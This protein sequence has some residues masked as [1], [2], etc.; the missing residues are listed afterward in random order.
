M[1]KKLLEKK[2]QK[3]WRQQK[4]AKKWSQKKNLQRDIFPKIKK[5]ADKNF[6]Q[7]NV[8]PEKNFSSKKMFAK[9]MSA[10]KNNKARSRQGQGK[11]KTMSGQGQGKIRAKG[12]VIKA[13]SL[14]QDQGKERSME[15]NANTI[16]TSNTIWWVLT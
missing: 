9:K 8:L 5:I 6:F 2:L 13:R 14:M 3:N 10:E 4:I 11:V 16:S 7:K 12:K 1:T 15:S